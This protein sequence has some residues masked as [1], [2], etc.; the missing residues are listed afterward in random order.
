MMIQIFTLP[1]F[2]ESWLGGNPENVIRLAGV[3]LLAAAGA[4][5]F[6]KTK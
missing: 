4:V 2:Y 3:L 5:F 1:L 6:V